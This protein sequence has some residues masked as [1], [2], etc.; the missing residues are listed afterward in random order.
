MHATAN[1]IDKIVRAMRKISRLEAREQIESRSC[2]WTVDDDGSLVITLKAPA[3]IGHAI[4]NAI[5]KHAT[6]KKG[7]PYA[8]TAADTLVGLILEDATVHGEVVVHVHPD[9]VNLEDGPAIAPE[10]AEA[11]ACNGTVT[12]VMETP[13]GPVVLDRQRAANRRQRRWLA[14]RHHTCQIKG[15]DHAGAFDVHHVVERGK[16]GRTRLSNL[17]RLCAFHHRLV[18]LHHLHVTLNPDRTLDLAFP[19]GNPLDR[20]IEQLDFE[21]PTP[22]PGDAIGLWYGDKL[23]LDLVTFGLLHGHPAERYQKA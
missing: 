23:Y 2:T 12:T 5:N 19:A 7:V 8:Q 18:H 22:E 3:E 1:Q 16:G 17:V 10:I 20:P 15:C 6:F 13:D 9:Q 4:V 21:P 14:F 11:L